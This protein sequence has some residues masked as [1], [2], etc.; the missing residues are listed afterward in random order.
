MATAQTGDGKIQGTKITSFPKIG[1]FIRIS[2]VGTSCFRRPVTDLI[3]C[4]RFRRE[5]LFL[6][7]AIILI[8]VQQKGWVFY[9]MPGAYL[10]RI[11]TDQSLFR[12]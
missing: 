2:R 7:S 5:A 9:K 8:L 1:R 10:F 3:E 4:P 6:Q 11:I 12:G